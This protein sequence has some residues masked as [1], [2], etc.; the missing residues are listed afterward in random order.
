[1][2]FAIY[3]AL[4]HSHIRVM[5]ALAKELE[6][7]GH[8]VCAIGMEDHAPVFHSLDMEFFPVCLREFPRGEL[9]RRY[10]PVREMYGMDALRATSAVGCDVVAGVLKD[11]ERAV[12]ASGADALLLDTSARGLEVIAMHMGMPFAHVSAQLHDDYSGV[13]PHWFFDWPPE[14]SSEAI[15]R[16]KN[17]L[18]FL[19]ELGAPARSAALDYLAAR[20]IHPDL[21]TPYPFFLSTDTWITQVP[22]EFDF[23]NQ[24]W[25]EHLFHAG[26]ISPREQSSAIDFPWERLTGESLIYVSMGTMLT[27]AKQRLRMAVQA[28]QGAGRQVV[29]STGPQIGV[30]EIGPLA[31]NTIVLPYVPQTGILERAELFVTHGGL[32]SVLES[33]YRGVPLVVLPI[34]FDQPGVAA[35]V[36]YHGVGEFLNAQLLNQK[37]LT[38][39]IV[40]VLG[41]PS[42]KEAARKLQAKIAWQD[43][44]QRAAKHLH[45]VMHR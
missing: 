12:R 40:S 24:L 41:N 34:S 44:A 6:T 45:K 28:A 20:N 25:P 14:T 13:T 17:N 15:E 18:N 1:M 26:L 38:E 23:E 31:A 42:Y 29:V 7:F 10:E 22:K 27:N 37:L 39:T 5:S 3:T 4:S 8:S 2:K 19:R 21:T 33:L 30:E 16:N 36:A 35:R 32:N 9:Q 43:G 11:G